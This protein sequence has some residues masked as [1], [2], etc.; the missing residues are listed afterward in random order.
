M[1]KTR[2]VLSAILAGVMVLAFTACGN[3]EKKEPGKGGGAK[4]TVNLKVWGAQ[5]DQQ[6]LGELITSF[7]EANKEK[8]YNITLGVV[9]ENDAKT[10][11][12]E[13]PDAAPDVFAF[14]NDQLVDLVKAGA[15]YEITRNKEAVISANLPATVEASTVNGKLYGY[16]MTADNGYFLYYDKSVISEEQVK[17]L[18]GILAAAKGKNKKV[19]MDVS[20]GWYIASFF[21]GGGGTLKID[22]DGK[23]IADFNNEKGLAVAEAIK[24]FT[25]HPSFLTGDDAVLTGGMGDTIAAGVS[26]TWNADAIKAKLGN[27]YAAAKL[28]TFTVNGKQTQMF[29]FSGSKLVGVSKGTKAP[30]DAMAFAEWITNEASQA[31]RFAKR[32]LGPSN[33]KVAESAEVKANVALSALA[34]QIPFSQPQ[35]NVLGTYWAP[36][37]AF[38]AQMEAKD[39][40]KTLQEQLDAMVKA[41]KG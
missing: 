24:A 34:A 8:N 7:K 33:K 6:L 39:Y 38:G 18:D 10:K 4:E 17:T 37:E 29:T 19:F 9:G 27:N 20:N 3:G 40:S 15:L 31:K 30:V 14:A 1:K 26:G 11:I 36:A 32:A 5:E 2:R 21:L 41:I 28:P 13:D 16:P 23:Q 22:A 12:L 35:N 25:A